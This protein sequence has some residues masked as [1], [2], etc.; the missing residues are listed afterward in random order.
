MSDISRVINE[1]ERSAPGEFDY[2]GE[3]AQNPE[4]F[5]QSENPYSAVDFAA[6]SANPFEYENRAMNF[7]QRVDAVSRAINQSA[8]NARNAAGYS[9]RE[10]WPRQTYEVSVIEKVALIFL[11]L[12][13]PLGGIIAG[14]IYF[15]SASPERKRFGKVV[16]IVSVLPMALIFLFVLIIIVSLVGVR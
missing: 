3:S 10:T 11:A 4:S 2:S 8:E 6:F 13:I 12:V 7:E 16:L 5:A 14:L 1:T 15:F 9:D